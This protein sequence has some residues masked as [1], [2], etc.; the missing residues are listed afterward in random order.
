MSAEIFFDQMCPPWERV[1]KKPWKRFALRWLPK[2][3]HW[4]IH[5]DDHQPVL[6]GHSHNGHHVIVCNPIHKENMTE[7]FVR[8][9]CETVIPHYMA[10]RERPTFERN[11]LH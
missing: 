8:H 1:Y 6:L 11:D 7:D 3:F 10:H 9:L 4:Y 5:A 2:R